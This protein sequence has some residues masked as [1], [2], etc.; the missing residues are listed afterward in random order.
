LEN[1]K[2]RDRLEHLSIDDRIRKNVKFNLEQA[3]KTQRG[4]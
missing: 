2:G 4:R 1:V 3:M